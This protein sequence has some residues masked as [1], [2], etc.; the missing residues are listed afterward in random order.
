MRLTATRAV[1]GAVG[2]FVAASLSTTT[3]AVVSRMKAG[4][5]ARSRPSGRCD[6]LR[7]GWHRGP[8]L[9]RPIEERAYETQVLPEPRGPPGSLTRQY[10]DTS[11][12]RH[13]GWPTCS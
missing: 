4:A 12:P 7:P 8:D 5:I 6:A 3:H 11:S 2:A 10:D 9:G 1:K 13:D